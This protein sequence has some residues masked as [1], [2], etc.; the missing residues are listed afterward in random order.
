MLKI[1]G[2]EIDDPA[3]LDRVSKLVARA[4]RDRHEVV[5]VHGGG[6]EI[7]RLLGKLGVE[8]RFVKGFRYT[9]LQTLEAV[10]M[11]L[12]GL[13]NKR[14]VRSLQ[15][16]G[17][18]AIGLSGVDGKILTAKRTTREGEDVGFV[19]EI[20][21]V[22]AAALGEL[23]QK[24]VVVLSPISISADLSTSLNVNA[25]YAAAAVASCIKSELAIFL[26]NV[27]GVI[28]DGAVIA[29]LR[30]NDFLNLKKSGIIDGGMIP[31]VEAALRAIDGGTA[32]AFITDAEG[33][34]RI[35]SGQ[36]AGT[37]VKK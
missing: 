7:T 33:A 20:D 12:S 37:E 27:E 11:M 34:S 23:I 30:K 4:Q 3:F 31:K 1:G 10:E 16:N 19:G 32:K 14:L 2:N 36:V 22:N 21:S 25:D 35:L 13:I 9:D 15:Q 5:L 17:V 24:F 28:N 29:T 6:K 18:N 8:T 26:S